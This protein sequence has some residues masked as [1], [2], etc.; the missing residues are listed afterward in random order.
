[1]WEGS[2]LNFSNLFSYVVY[3]YQ[4]SGAA[5]T[6]KLGKIFC[7]AFTRHFF[8][9]LAVF[10]LFSPDKKIKDAEKVFLLIFKLADTQNYVK[11][12]NKLNKQNSISWMTMIY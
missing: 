10:L 12:K 11:V 8:S 7:F 3:F 6:R 2:K 4:N 5:H 9:F 1:M